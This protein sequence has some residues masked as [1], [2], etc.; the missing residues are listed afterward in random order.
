MLRLVAFFAI[1]IPATALAGSMQGN[2]AIKRW[3]MMD[4]CTKQ[5]QAA[6]P[7]FTTE[8][9]AKRDAKLKE[10]LASHNLPPRE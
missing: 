10:C 2:V 4:E 8:S 5:A 9:N 1:L 6:F 7:D 3:K